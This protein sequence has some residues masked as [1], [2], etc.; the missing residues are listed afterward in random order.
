MAGKLRERPAAPAS[1]AR[2]QLAAAINERQ[3]HI[4]RIAAL[5]AAAERA[6]QTAWDAEAKIVQAKEAIVAG[7]AQRVAAL[8]DGGAL[9]SSASVRADLTDAQ[10]ALEAANTARQ[11]IASELE[12]LRSKLSYRDDAIERAVCAVLHEELVGAGTIAAMIEE[13]RQAR[14]KVLDLGLAFNLL[15]GRHVID[16]PPDSLAFTIPQ[17]PYHWR[18]DPITRPTTQERLEAAFAALRQDAA[19]VVQV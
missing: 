11:E 4:T 1:A 14:A 18:G 3:Q 15:V 10:D 19:A 8:V 2:E 5:E 9:P 6:Q 16:E 7:K 12:T 17:A 13:L